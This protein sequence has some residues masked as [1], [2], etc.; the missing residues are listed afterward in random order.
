MLNDSDSGNLRY[1]LR[2]CIS[3]K[4]SGNVHAAGTRPT[5]YV[6]RFSPNDVHPLYQFKQVILRDVNI[7]LCNVAAIEKKG[8][9]LFLK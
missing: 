4:L 6:A 8:T 9:C 7:T 5:V 3:D 1:G 2:V